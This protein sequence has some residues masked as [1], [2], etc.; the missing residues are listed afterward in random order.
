MEVLAERDLVRLPT[1][2]RRGDVVGEGLRLVR[3]GKSVGGRLGGA[4]RG[5][6]PWDG[7]GV[8]RYTGPYYLAMIAPV[9]VLGSGLVSVG[10]YAWL[11]M[12]GVILL[13]SKLLWWS[14]EHLWG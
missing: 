8:C 11:A 9:V 3:Q 14:I 4:G 6:G 7:G 10:I 5:V 13:G 1:S 2:E 12:A